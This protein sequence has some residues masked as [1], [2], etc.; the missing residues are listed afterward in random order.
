MAD[1]EEVQYKAEYVDV[2]EGEES[3]VTNWLPRPGKAKVTYANG[4]TYE[5]TFDAERMKNGDGIF[6]WMQAAEED[7]EEATMLAKYEGAYVDGKKAGIGKMTFP[8]QDTYTGEW[9]NNLMEGE[10]TYVYKASGDAY[11]G[12]W[13]KG[14]KEGQG[15][16]QFGADDSIMQGTWEN[17]SI[18]SGTWRFSDGTVYSGSFKDGKPTGQ[19]VYVFPSGITQKGEYVAKPLGEG[20]EEEGAPP[21][22]EWLGQPVEAC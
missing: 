3:Q 13:V 19:G 22:M 17:G 5:G 18:T 10:G 8:N 20:E 11:S 1:D 14:K 12:T 7:G 2:P 16:Y 9:S 15:S 4:S 6:T 21:K